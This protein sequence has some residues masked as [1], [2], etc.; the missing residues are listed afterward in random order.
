[1]NKS[2][3][4]IDPIDYIDGNGE[5]KTISAGRKLTMIRKIGEKCVLRYGNKLFIIDICKIKES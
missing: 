2:V 3:T 1:M 4:C 5:N